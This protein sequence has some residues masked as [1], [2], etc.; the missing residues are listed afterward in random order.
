M[1]RDTYETALREGETNITPGLGRISQRSDLALY[2]QVSEALRAFIEQVG[3]TDGGELPTEDM[4]SRHYEVSR[5][6]IRHALQLLEADG[7]I[8]KRRAKSAEVLPMRQRQHGP[9]QI[10]SLD[11]IVALTQRGSLKVI[12]FD[13]EVSAEASKALGLPAALPL[14]CLTNLLE[15]DQRPFAYNK[16]YFPPEIGGALQASDF[17]E[18]AIYRNIEKKLSIAISDVKVNVQSI[19]ASPSVAEHLD[20]E[21]GASVLMLSLLFYDGNQNPMQ[22]S[23]NHYNGEEF[24]LSYRFRKAGGALA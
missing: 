2:R 21:P 23:V 19:L 18:V 7:L 16:I 22:F 12:S 17:T 3:F 20:C 13:R 14:N 10:N 24:V 8:R 1:D 9:W 15:V 4:L 6:T 5:I 11:D